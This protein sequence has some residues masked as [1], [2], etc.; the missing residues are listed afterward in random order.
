MFRQAAFGA[1]AIENFW[2]GRRGI[3]KG[4]IQIPQLAIGRVVKDETAR[5]IENGNTGRELVQCAPMRIHL[6]AKI[7]A[8]MFEIGHVARQT[9]VAELRRYIGDIEHAALARN[10]GRHAP[11]PIFNART[12]LRECLA[13]RLVQQLDALGNDI[14]A[15]GTFNRM[16]IGAVH[17]G[18]F[19]L[20]VAQPCG[21]GCRI[22]HGAQAIAL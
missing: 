17:P 21:A 4:R 18:Q 19:A 6:A 15:P 7:S 1:Q 2:V 12:C 5:G 8:H 20:R 10:N 9:A 11:T 3:E 14:F 22:Q 13:H 16:H